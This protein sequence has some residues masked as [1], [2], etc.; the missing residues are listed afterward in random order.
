[1]TQEDLRASTLWIH[2]ADDACTITRLGMCSVHVAR[3]PASRVHEAVG[4]WGTSRCF[5]LNDIRR[6]SGPYARRHHQNHQNLSTLQA[7][8]STRKD[9]ISSRI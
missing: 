1:M 6:V 8:N 3:V 2:T 4:L 9:V 7:A 5:G